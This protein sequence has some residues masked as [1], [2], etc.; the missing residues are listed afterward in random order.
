MYDSTPT[1][2]MDD[3][4]GE[5][6]GDSLGAND[7]TKKKLSNDGAEALKKCLEENKG[8]R[9][10]CKSKID[11]LRSSSAPRKRPLLPLRLKSG[12]LTDV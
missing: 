9:N 4:K 10:K 8:D 3:E 6:S 2:T 1:Y 12:S 11:A 5:S 7:G